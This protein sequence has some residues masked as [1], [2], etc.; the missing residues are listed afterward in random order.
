MEYKVNE[1]FHSLQGEG[2]WAGT[3]MFFVRLSGCNLSCPWCDTDHN[4]GK[5]MSERDI[6]NILDKL[7]D[8]TSGVF[9]T[10]VCITGG[11]PTIH[12]LASLCKALG[13]WYSLHLETNG[14]RAL[15]EQ[16][17]FD[18]VTVSPKFPPG[19]DGMPQFWGDELKVPVSEEVTDLLADQCAGWGHF[20]Y[21]YLQPVDGDDLEKNAQRCLELASKMTYP[22]RVSMQGHKRLN[23][24]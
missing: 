12:D 16:E 3:P 7:Q 18:W 5:I 4:I 2:Y 10:R 20:H 19:F 15:V 14:T 21:R 23:L 13:E 22:W 1:I 11:E 9:I 24:R 6:L 17:R 8:E